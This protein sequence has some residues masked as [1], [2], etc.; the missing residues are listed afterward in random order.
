MIWKDYNRSRA[1]F[2]VCAATGRRSVTLSDDDR[3]PKRIRDPVYGLIVFGEGKSDF[4]DE[5]DGM[6]G[7]YTPEFQRLRRINQLGFSPLTYPGATH[8]RFSHSVGTYHMARRLI[9]LINRRIIQ[10]RIRDDIPVDLGE[11]RQRVALLAAL[12]HDIGHGPFSH[13]F[14][15]VERDAHRRR[16]VK[17]KRERPK[18]NTEPPPRKHEQWSAKI[19]ASTDTDV[20]KVLEKSPPGGN[21]PRF[22]TKSPSFSNRSIQRISTALS[23]PVS[24]TP[25]GWTTCSGIA[26]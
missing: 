21:S 11:H 10:G 22:T 26:S 7:N 25:T 1:P 16:E 13:A 6:H 23:S 3:K 18:D 15:D 4:Q 12:L 17:R 9:D 5:T 20:Y 19:V 8:S 2:K 14:E 24:S